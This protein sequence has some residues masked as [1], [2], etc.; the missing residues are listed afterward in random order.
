MLITVILILMGLFAVG[1]VYCLA[2][3]VKQRSIAPQVN[4]VRNELEDSEF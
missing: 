4:C 2:R 1:G 3:R